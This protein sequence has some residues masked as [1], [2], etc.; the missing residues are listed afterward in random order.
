MKAL[1]S[2]ATG[3]PETLEVGDLPDPQ[4]GPGQV[5]IAVKACAVNFPDV[6]M[7][8]DKY[9]FRPERPFAPGGEIAG[10]VDQVGEG[11]ADWK[12]GDRV[13]ASTGTG[14]MAEKVIVEPARIYALPEGRS[15][16]EG[17]ALLMTYGTTIH[18]L[19]DRGG[20]KE[21]DVLLVLGAAGGV[22]MAAVELGKAFG[23][24]VIAAVSSEEKA[25]ACREAGA[26]GTVVY[27]RAPFDKD[28][29]KALADQFKAAVGPNGADLIY[30]AVGG[31]YCEPALR[32]IAW[33]GRYL[34]IG[35]PAGIPKLPLNLTLLKSCDVRGVFWGAHAMREPEH[36][37]GNI[38]RLF[39]LWA[40][41]KISP[42]VTA[43]FPLAEGG[44]AIAMLEERKAIGKVVVTID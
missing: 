5:R 21:G 29:S 12:V 11:V 20:I 40:D 14:G 18:A 25:A 35:F 32:S 26:E 30:D 39:R 42:R 22:G 37:R 4:A 1:L 33:E 13:I 16:K 43:S 17:A 3:G 31:D 2:R 27:G 15:F 19:V 38:A 44:K 10:I 24:K 34:V 36:N 6:L 7:I 41:G 8:V 23:A 9:Q 28:Q